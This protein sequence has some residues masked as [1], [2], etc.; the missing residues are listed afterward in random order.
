MKKFLLSSVVALALGSVVASNTV[1]VSAATQDEASSETAEFNP[2]NNQYS[3]GSLEAE[4]IALP[5]TTAPGGVP[6]G[7]S[8][9][10]GYSD[11]GWK[12]WPR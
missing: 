4:K 6:G 1:V 10:P 2:V 3:V 8:R 11:T 7:W 5:H 9:V 12:V